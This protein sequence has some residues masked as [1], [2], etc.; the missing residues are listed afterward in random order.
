MPT[1]RETL[2]AGTSLVAA[3]LFGELALAD[4]EDAYETA[5][6]A[7]GKPACDR[8]ND[9]G[10]LRQASG[11]ATGGVSQGMPGATWLQ[12]GYVVC[13]DCLGESKEFRTA[14]SQYKDGANPWV[15]LARKRIE[16]LK[17]EG[18]FESI[19]K[20][21]MEAQPQASM[22]PKFNLFAQKG[23]GGVSKAKRGNYLLASFRAHFRA[24]TLTRGVVRAV[25][26]R[27]GGADAT[28]KAAGVVQDSSQFIDRNLLLTCRDL[29]AFAAST[30]DVKYREPCGF[31]ARYNSVPTLRNKALPEKFAFH[32][33]G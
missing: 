23:A 18:K 28:R 10:Q 11:G 3:S 30:L 13:P 32:Y 6:N 14:I 2:V 24:A 31:P 17:S 16:Q 21:A 5:R 19:K 20:K 12:D 1:R 8:C 25:V 26:L 29:M 9:R 4:G 7:V 15:D 22:F 27:W 33:L